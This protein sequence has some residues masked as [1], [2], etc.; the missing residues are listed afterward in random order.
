MKKILFLLFIVPAFFANA[1]GPIKAWNDQLDDFIES[2]NKIDT[3]LSQLYSGKGADVFMFTYFDPESGN[4]VKEATISNPEGT[5][6][7]DETTIEQARQIVTNHLSSEASKNARLN[8]ILNE[9]AKRNTG[10]VLLYTSE[11]NTQPKKVV[12]SPKEIKK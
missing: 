10:I 8:G 4:V 9:F 6:A 2:Y 3:D 5:D 12:I 1:Q 11:G 7:V